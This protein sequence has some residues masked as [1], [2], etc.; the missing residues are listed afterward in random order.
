MALKIIALVLPLGLDTFAVAA[1][2]GIAGTSPKQR[3]R[4]SVLFA[5]F[6]GGMPLVGL[7]VGRPLGSA[8]GSAADY[9]AIGVLL[10]LAVHLLI[11]DEG[12]PNLAQLQG[13]GALASVALGISISL[14]ELAIGF[15]LGLLRLPILPVIILIAAQAFTVTQLGMRLGDRVGEGSGKEL[16]ASP[17]RR[18]RS[19]RSGC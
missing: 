15:T 14:D 3:L 11:A 9:I 6:E 4:T 7:A 17:G 1:A 12:E 2:L 10:A 19:W 16:N 18:S 5:S 13:R 8:I